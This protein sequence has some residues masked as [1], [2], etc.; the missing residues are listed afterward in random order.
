MAFDPLSQPQEVVGKQWCHSQKLFALATIFTIEPIA[1][2][3]VDILQKLF[4][5][6]KERKTTT[7]KKL[8]AINKNWQHVVISDVIHS[9][10]KEENKHFVFVCC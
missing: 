4:N 2:F 1:S 10:A 7:T 5:K 6:K 3:R 8:F 9:P